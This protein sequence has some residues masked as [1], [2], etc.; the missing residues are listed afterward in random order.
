MD[1]RN[2]WT[3]RTL[4]EFT[5]RTFKWTYVGDALLMIETLVKEGV[6]IKDNQGLLLSMPS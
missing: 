2:F 3:K 5:I 6:L 1:L 4:T